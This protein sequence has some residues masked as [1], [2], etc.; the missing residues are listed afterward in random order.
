MKSISAINELMESH[1]LK[2]DQFGNLHFEAFVEYQSNIKNTSEITSVTIIRNGY[3]DGQIKLDEEGDLNSDDF[4]L[5]F[6]IKYQSYRFSKEN[7]SLLISG[8]SPK[9]SGKYSVLISPKP[10]TQE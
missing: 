8:N 5:D 1:N 7:N 9:M 3:Q 4:H 2:K 6:D 10:D